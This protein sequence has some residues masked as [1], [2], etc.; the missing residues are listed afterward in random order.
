MSLCGHPLTFGVSLIWFVIIVHDRWIKVCLFALIYSLR[1]LLVQKG[2]VTHTD[3]IKLNVFLLLFL[4]EKRLMSSCFSLGSCVTTCIDTE[5]KDLM[6]LWSKGTSTDSDYR[7]KVV[8]GHG[9]SKA[10]TE[11]SWK[12]FQLF[13]CLFL[14]LYDKLQI[15]LTFNFVRRI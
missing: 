10:P 1:L 15:E 14:C 8:I 12:S 3:W 9:N 13:N 6:P 7:A 4:W 2:C 11:Y 5:K